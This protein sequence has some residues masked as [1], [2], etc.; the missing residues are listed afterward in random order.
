MALSS[1]LDLPGTAAATGVF[2]PRE[3]PWV[4]TNETVDPQRALLALDS[5]CLAEAADLAAG[6]KKS[7]RALPDLR[8][9]GPDL[10]QLRRLMARAKALL[11]RPP[12]FAVIDALPLDAWDAETAAA[13]FW[14]LGQC[15]GRP[16][17]Q[18]WDGTLLYHVRDSERAFGYGVRGST[19]NVEL[20]FHIDNAFGLA[21]PDY[22]GLLCLR[23]ALEGGVSRFCSLHCLHARMLADHPDLLARLYRPLLWDRQAEHAPDAPKVVRAPM[24]SRDRDGNLK[25]RVNVSLVRKGYDLAGEVLDREAAAALDALCTLADDPALWVELPLE[26]GQVQYLNNRDVGHYRSRFRDHKAPEL[27]RHLI[28]SW[29]RDWGAADYD[30]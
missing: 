21:P 5:A 15:I 27:K 13:V 25:A 17:A 18:K 9:G 12:G 11:D 24:F 8:G 23:P 26:R 4:W 3:D 19:T 6:L 22:V 20:N 10:P 2:Q 30:G 16:V 14:V 28:R 7:G 1:V 29:H